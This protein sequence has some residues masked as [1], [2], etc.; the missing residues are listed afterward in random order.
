MGRPAVAPVKPSAPRAPASGV[1]VSPVRPAPGGDKTTREIIPPWHVLQEKLQK[2][3]RGAGAKP[4]DFVPAD[5]AARE[6]LA[7]QERANEGW[8]PLL[9][10]PPTEPPSSGV[11]V[12]E[13]GQRVSVPAACVAPASDNL[14]FKVYTLA[15]LES[16]GDAP[17][18][19]R[20]SRASFDGVSPRGAAARLPRVHAALRAFGRATF[21]WWTTRPEGGG[22]RPD[23]RIAL[24]KPFDDL[25]DE[26][27]VVVQAVDWK[28]YGVMLGIVV[29]AS[30]TLLFAVLTAAELTDDLRPGS[31]AH[32]AS[33]ETS[34]RTMPD[35]HGVAAS[36]LLADRS[37]PPLAGLNVALAPA[38]AA[39]AVT[40]A[41][42]LDDV[43]EPD[44]APQ[45]ARRPPRKAPKAKT[46]KLTFRNADAIFNP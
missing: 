38:A 23:L 10:P 30:L 11:R 34:I 41:G 46:N 22:V 35:V 15:E 43:L 1:K 33:R 16:R 32:L 20:M 2:S 28:R 21:S 45:T 4:A 18:F 36:A 9:A 7:A 42:E 31:A 24:R 26:L 44:A 14:S 19:L 25:G 8:T 3:A 12:S 40:S 29:G 5:Q 27:Q 39:Q 13:S 37:A 17:I 6:A